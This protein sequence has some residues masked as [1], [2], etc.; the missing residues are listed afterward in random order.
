M[1]VGIRSS[2]SS[3]LAAPVPAA[4]PPAGRTVPRLVWVFVGAVV[5]LEIPYPLL[6]GRARDIDIVATVLVFAT[7]STVHAAISRGLRYAAT[8]L[9][10]AVGIGFAAEAIGVATGVPFGHYRYGAG[11]GP[12]VAGVPVV[13]PFAWAMMTHPAAVVAQHLTVRLPL[14]IAVAAWALASWDVFLDPQM[15]AA[16]EWRWQ[17]VGLTL[18]G[19]GDV[20]LTNYAGW[21]LVALIVMAVVVPAVAIRNATP[22]AGDRSLPDDRPAIALWLWSAASSTLAMAG[23]LL[24]P[25]VAGWGALAMGVVAVPL[26]LRLRRPAEIRRR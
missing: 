12:A 3:G 17:G 20:P 26:V 14:R 13:I 5:A 15:V 23:F 7:A 2:G 4:R 10:A 25:A 19:V 8:M 9:V 18:P 22:E 11:L 21:L 6:S 24:R 16:G 1:T